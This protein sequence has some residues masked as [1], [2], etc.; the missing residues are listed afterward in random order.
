MIIM[1]KNTVKFF[2]GILHYDIDFFLIPVL[3]VGWILAMLL[4][5]VKD[6]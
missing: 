4:G 6:V 2:K 5:E 1:I 3:F